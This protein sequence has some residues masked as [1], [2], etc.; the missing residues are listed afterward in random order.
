[1]LR[2]ATAH[3]RQGRPQHLIS[4]ENGSQLENQNLIP[5]E[6]LPVNVS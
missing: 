4:Q 5:N 1:M 2:A 3:D 6:I